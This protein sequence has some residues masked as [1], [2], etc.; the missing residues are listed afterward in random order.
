MRS[1]KPGAVSSDRLA[2]RRWRSP[3]N[4]R[5][6]CGKR[7][8]AALSSKAYL[9]LE[10]NHLGRSELGP[11]LFFSTMTFCFASARKCGTKGTSF[12]TPASFAIRSK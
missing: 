11:R 2:Q 4:C 6:R 12:G 3:P 5:V 10:I 7:L 8:P 1:F 9:S